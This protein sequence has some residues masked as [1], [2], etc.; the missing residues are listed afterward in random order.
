MNRWQLKQAV[1]RLIVET[2]ISRVAAPVYEVLVRTELAADRLRPAPAPDHSLDLQLTAMIKTFERPATLRRLVDS[3][4]LRYPTLPI[5]VV[6]D[7]ERPAP[8]EGVETVVLPFDSGVSAGRQAGL[9]RVRTPYLLVLDDDFVFMRRTEL[10]P[11]L[12]KLVRNERIDILG[13]QL[14]DLPS[15]RRRKPVNGQIF[16]TSTQPIA[17][18]G[19]LIEGLP[20]CDKVTN[21]YLARTERLKLVGWHP[22]LRRIDHADFFTRAQGV[23]VTAFDRDLIGLHVQTPFDRAYMS[24]RMNIEHDRIILAA[25]WGARR[26][27]T[28]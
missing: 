23:L 27:T 2:P 20:V 12:A 8:L 14:I 6:D 9:E 19:S 1:K 25:R 5:V 13:G 15:L 18:I 10:A 28:H 3:I 26:E 16:A 17:P 21:F 22:D 24:H 4:R 11:S 7:S